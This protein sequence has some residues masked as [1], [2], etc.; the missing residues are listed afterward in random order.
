[1]APP[2]RARLVGPVAGGQALQHSEAPA[3][4]GGETAGEGESLPTG[5][6]PDD[7][8]VSVVFALTCLA[9]AA[10]TVG[11]GWVLVAVGWWLLAR[12]WFTHVFVPWL[13]TATARLSLGLVAWA[14]VLWL[15]ALLWRRYNH[16]RY[17]LRERR[18]LQALPRWAEPWLW[19]ET[20]FEDPPERA[21]RT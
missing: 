7:L 3:S 18:R 15:A 20:V 12:L 19:S 10:I 16:A 17:H 14:A 6:S 9:W 11:A 13:V 1:M 4:P 2:R 21:R 8:R 5:A